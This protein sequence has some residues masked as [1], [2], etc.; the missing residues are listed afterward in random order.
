MPSAMTLR[1]GLRK[2]APLVH[3]AQAGVERRF[4]RALQID[5]ERRVDGQAALVEPL[6]AIALFEVLPDVLEE[7][8][9]EGVR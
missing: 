7:E 5:I 1:R 2:P 9:R 8:R 6:G 3:L 4:R